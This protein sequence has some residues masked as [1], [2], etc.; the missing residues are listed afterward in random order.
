MGAQLD[1]EYADRVRALAL[2]FA[3][4]GDSESAINLL[5]SYK[6]RRKAQRG[7][8]SSREHAALGDLMRYRLERRF[9]RSRGP[10][11]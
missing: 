1:D 7:R 10:V 2:D 6:R 5:E 4:L 11:A 3:R 8:Y 9:A